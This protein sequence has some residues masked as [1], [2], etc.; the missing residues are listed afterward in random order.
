MNR[1]CLD[2]QTLTTNGS[3]CEPCTHRRRQQHD[4]NRPPRKQR[5]HHS[6]PTYRRTSAQLRQQWND[7]PFTVCWLCGE[8]ARLGDPWQA[9]HV[10]PGNLN[11]PLQ[12]AH[13]SC[14]AKRGAT[15]PPHPTT[16]PH[17]NPV[18]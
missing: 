10:I 4:R 18:K 14:N 3:R 2:C 17:Q 16:T 7:D 8:G 15:P 5:G 13:R 6:D 1:P 9:D 12:P 11:S